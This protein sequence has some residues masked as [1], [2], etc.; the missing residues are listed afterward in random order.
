MPFL[1]GDAIPI[2]INSGQDRLC[3][4][5]R[6]IEESQALA[7]R[8]KIARLGIRQLKPKRSEE[9]RVLTTGDTTDDSGPSNDAAPEKG[10]AGMGNFDL[11]QI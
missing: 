6:H 7:E 10:G 1:A 2:D 4:L 11:E 5:I 8:H 9:K 3:D